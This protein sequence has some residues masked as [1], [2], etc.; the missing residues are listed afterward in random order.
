[1]IKKKASNI[2]E[3][4]EKD[5]RRCINVC[6]SSIK[7]QLGGLCLVPSNFVRSFSINT[8]FLQLLTTLFMTK[9][10]IEIVNIILKSLKWMADNTNI[11]VL[12]SFYQRGTS[13]CSFVC[14]FFFSYSGL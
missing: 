13:V 11:L 1:M 4:H 8:C 14:F 12:R 6:K 2:Y 9:I 10:I 5:G 3:F 7:K